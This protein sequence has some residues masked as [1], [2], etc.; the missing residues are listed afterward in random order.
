MILVNL[1]TSTV[2]KKVEG[3]RTMVILELTFERFAADRPCETLERDRQN[4]DFPLSFYLFPS[5]AQNVSFADNCIC[6]M[7]AP[8]SIA[9]M[10]PKFADPNTPFGLA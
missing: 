1:I 9:L 7:N 2:R 8:V 3:K 4:Q 5:G 10:R 6:R